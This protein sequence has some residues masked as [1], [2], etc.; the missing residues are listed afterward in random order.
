MLSMTSIFS[1]RSLSL[2][3]QRLWNVFVSGSRFFFSL[4]RRKVDKSSRFHENVFSI[5]L[6]QRRKK[7]K[8][9]KKLPGR[10]KYKFMIL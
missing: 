6:C 1:Y 4:M 9:E 10:E 3:T 8:E 7:R 5:T 2:F